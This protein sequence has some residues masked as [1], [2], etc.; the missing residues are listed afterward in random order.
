MAHRSRRLVSCSF[1]CT[2][3]SYAS[4]PPATSFLSYFAST[5]AESEHKRVRLKTILFLQGSTS[6]DP[7]P[8]HKRLLD[9]QKV[10]KLELAI[11]EGKVRLHAFFSLISLNSITSSSL[12]TTDL[13][14]LSWP[15]TCEMLFLPKLIVL[16]AER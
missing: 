2:A 16:S 10:L 13:P 14:S 9:N 7:V 1:W 5:T 8:I 3:S 11:V 6:Y 15:A 4:N 12:E